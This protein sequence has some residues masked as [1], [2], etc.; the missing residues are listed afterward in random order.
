MWGATIKLKTSIFYNGQR[1]DNGGFNVFFAYRNQI[2]RSLSSALYKWPVRTNES[3]K[4]YIMRFTL[5]SMEVLRKRQKKDN[6]CYN[7]ENYDDK[8]IL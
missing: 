3:T 2:Y 7:M 6:V 4:N 8:I 5:K 1:P